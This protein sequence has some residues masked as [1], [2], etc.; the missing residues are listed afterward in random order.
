MNQ[1]LKEAKQAI[2][3]FLPNY[4]DEGLAALLAH[5]QNGKL[6]FKSCCCLIG[7]ATAT[8]KL[9]PEYFSAGW[10]GEN[11]ASHLDDAKRLPM[12]EKAEAAFNS[13]GRATLTMVEVLSELDKTLDLNPIRRRRVIP[14]I[15]AEL[16]RRDRE[17]LQQRLLEGV[18]HGSTNPAIPF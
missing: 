1:Q 9:Q 12:A 4:T 17:R 10:Q 3:A 2:R 13:I 16:R 5:A 6:A 15:K 8:G 14:I 11:H 7:C 18:M